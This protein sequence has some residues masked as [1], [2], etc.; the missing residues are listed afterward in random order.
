MN[1]KS[2]TI[3]G[4]EPL[5]DYP[6]HWSITVVIH[7]ESGETEELGFI[8]KPDGT[9]WQIAGKHSIPSEN[10]TVRFEFGDEILD[11]NAL[12]LCRACY[13]QLQQKLVGKS[14]Q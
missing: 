10:V 13:T 9:Y 5:P 7:G 14:G 2:G 1:I 8:R 6:G 11:E 12:A 4:G 3:I